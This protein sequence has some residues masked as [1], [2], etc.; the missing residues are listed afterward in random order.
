MQRVRLNTAHAH[1][2]LSDR[3]TRAQGWSVLDETA[4]LA[5]SRGLSHQLRSI[6]GIR[7]GFECMSGIIGR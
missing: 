4:Q 5:R 2:L 6:D 3:A 7:R 1:I